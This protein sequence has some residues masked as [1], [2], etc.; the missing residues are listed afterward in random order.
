MRT[1]IQTHL[2]P[3]LLDL[4]QLGQDRGHAV[5]VQVTILLQCAMFQPQ[6]LHLLQVLR[7]GRG[8]VKR[9]GTCPGQTTGLGTRS[10]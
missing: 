2:I 1:S 7:A 10:A 8:G 9:G 5:L 6:V 3:L 4:L